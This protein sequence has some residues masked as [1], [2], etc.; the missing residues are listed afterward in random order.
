ML[1]TGKYYPPKRIDD[2]AFADDPVG[3]LTAIYNHRCGFM[4]DPMLC[5]KNLAYAARQHG[6]EFRFRSEVV[7]IDRTPGGEA[8]A[9]VT[10]AYGRSILAPVV[11]N[12][13]GPHS[14]IINRLAG[15]TDDMTIGHRP[16]RQEVFAAAVPVGLRLEDGAPFVSDLDVGQYFRPQP[17]GTMLIGGAEPDCDELHWVDDPDTNSE[18]PTVEVLETYMMRFARRVPEFGVP[19]QPTG[20]AALYDA[21]DDWVPIYDRS[22]LHG[23]FMACGIERQPVQERADRRPV[24]ARHHRSH[25]ERPRPRR[26]PAPVPRRPHRRADRPRRLLPQAPTAHT[27]GTV[28]G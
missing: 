14:G 3:E 28:M 11:V 16:L 25:D 22:S 19:S 23:Y 6:A 15:V 24:H 8:V 26:R 1:D 27:S 20:L 21:S 10:L 7:A 13:G 9:G 17:G 12:V 5:A 18:F 2:P 4:D